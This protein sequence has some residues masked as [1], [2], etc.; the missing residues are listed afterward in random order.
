MSTILPD[1]IVVLQ[2][3]KCRKPL[4]LTRDRNRELIDADIIP[5]HESCT[6]AKFVSGQGGRVSSS[7][8]VLLA[9]ASLAES[10]RTEFTEWD[11]TVAAWK[12]D[13]VRFGLRGYEKDHPDHKRVSMEIMGQKISSPIAR[14]YMKRVRTNTYAM[15]VAG[16]NAAVE[17]REL[18]ASGRTP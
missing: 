8:L 5:T 18:I 15:T 13:R 9:G 10:G 17:L 11:L 6:S 14:G 4:I 7:D 16:L 3:A 12:L 2:C 1:D